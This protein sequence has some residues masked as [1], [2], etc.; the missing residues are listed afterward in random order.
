MATTATTSQTSLAAQVG[1]I[2][3]MADAAVERIS[4]DAAQQHADAEVE[5]LEHQ[6]E[7]PQEGDRDEPGGL[8]Q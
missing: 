6:V 5:A 3:W 7:R 4:A 2:A 8:H 1:P